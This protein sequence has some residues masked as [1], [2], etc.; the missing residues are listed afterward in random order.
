MDHAPARICHKAPAAWGSSLSL[1]SISWPR[2][3]RQAPRPMFWR[4]PGSPCLASSPVA[5]LPARVAPRAMEAEMDISAHAVARAFHCIPNARARP[6]TFSASSLQPQ[7]MTSLRV[8]SELPCHWF[9]ATCCRRG[10]HQTP[11][12]SPRRGRSGAM[13]VSHPCSRE[14][15]ACSSRFAT[16]SRSPGGFCDWQCPVVGCR[17]PIFLLSL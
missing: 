1:P 9:L 7:L 15:L 11:G 5:T 3:Y 14:L 6:V 8:S 13:P 17:F 16:D 12:A 2:L 10:A 4:H